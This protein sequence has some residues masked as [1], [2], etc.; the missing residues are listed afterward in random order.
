MEMG[1]AYPLCS[2]PTE[3]DCVAGHVRLELRNVVTNYPL[4]SSIDFQEI[5]PNSSRAETIRV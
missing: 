2:W 3:T 5:N 4:E 1:R